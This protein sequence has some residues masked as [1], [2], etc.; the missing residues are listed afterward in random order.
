M[1]IA[2]LGQYPINENIVFT[3]PMRVVYNI[4]NELAKMHGIDV[5]VYSP[6]P[7]NKLFEKRIEIQKTPLHAFK[8]SPIGL[9]KELLKN[10]YDI[11]NLFA[12]SPFEILPFVFKKKRKTKIVYTVH[13][14]AYRERRLG[15]NYPFWISYNERIL[16]KM[17]DSIISVSQHLKNWIIEDYN[18]DPSKI[19]VIHNG[20]SINEFGIIKQTKLDNDNLFPYSTRKIVFIGSLVPVKGL[21]YLIEAMEYIIKYDENVILILVGRGPQEKELKKLVKSKKLTKY[22]KFVG[23]RPHAEIVGWINL[24]DI[25]VLPSIN[26]GSPGVLLE[27]IGCGKAIIATKCGGIPEL[28]K[29]DDIGL[30]VPPRSPELLAK[31]ILKGLEKEWNRKKIKEYAKKYSWT[32]ISKKY[33]CVYKNVLK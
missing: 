28:I 11:I 31:A 4:A 12:L 27:A 26:E 7:R 9:I 19:N 14:L 30:L 24:A 33:L 5:T 17:S 22:I 20:I 8:I 23:P 25:I 29:N 1:K 6:H 10:E 21:V 13:G 15:Y 3:G 18:I 16:L 32:E 2:I